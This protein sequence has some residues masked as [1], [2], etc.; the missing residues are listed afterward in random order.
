MAAD[1]IGIVEQA[2]TLSDTVDG[3][4]RATLRATRGVLCGGLGGIATLYDRPNPMPQD[5]ASSV[6]VDEMDSRIMAAMLA[7]YARG[8][9]VER[10]RSFSRGP[11]LRL[12]ELTE[13]PPKEHAAYRALTAEIGFEDVLLLRAGDPDGAG[14]LIGG[15]Q[16]NLV[17]ADRRRDGRLSRLAMHLAAGARLQRKGV[18]LAEA[19]A[20]IAPGGR[21]LSARGQAGATIEALRCAAARIDRARTKRGRADV[22]AALDGWTALVEGRWSLVDVFE[23]DGKRLILAVPNA[24]GAPD[25]RALRAEEQAI[26][27]YACIGYPNKL[28][29]YT[30]GIPE[31]TVATRLRSVC[32]KLGVRS[33][34]ALLEHVFATKRA[35]FSRAEVGGAPVIVGATAR[36][37]ASPLAVL[38]PAQ[39]EVASMAARGLPNHEIAAARGRS[40]QTV[41]NMLSNVYRKLGVTSRAELARLVGDP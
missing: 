35:T 17:P 41:A 2:Y 27:H 11:V 18:Q 26:V 8:S 19:E 9:D 30:L 7:E 36:A 32:R 31:G 3:W 5:L 14:V 21:L 4:L 37:T 25:P 28:I 6:V 15:P 13:K 23:K 22:D 16:P 33:R 20:I 39:R 24:P 29:A 34:G 38:P 10:G 12:S 40:P 1:L